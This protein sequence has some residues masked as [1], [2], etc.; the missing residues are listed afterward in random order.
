[1][2]KVV[3]AETAIEGITSGM[4]LL[5]GGF[6]KGGI[7]DFLLAALLERDIRDLAIVSNDTG[8]IENQL[9]SLMERGMVSHVKANYIGANPLTG[10]MLIDDPDSVELMP[11]GTMAE[12]IRAGGA[13]LGGILT[14]VGVGT[15]VEKGKSR[16]E[17][18]GKT[19]LFER[20]LRG[21][22]ALVHAKKADKMGNCFMKGTAKNMN[23]I[24]ATAAEYVIV[25]AEELVETGEI[26]PELVTVPG[27]LVDAVVRV[28]A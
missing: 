21:D 26:D 17:V 15:A 12:R 27:I 13:G 28:E 18:D 19:Y 16:V 6:L 24:M 7:P 22:F 1:M 5:V 3:S 23:A 14:P 10:K 4:T 25:E 9:Y 11:Q 2:D 20:P 8:T